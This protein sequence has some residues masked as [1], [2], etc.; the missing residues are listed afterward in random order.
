MDKLYTIVGDWRLPFI[1]ALLSVA[2]MVIAAHTT[3]R[4]YPWVLWSFYLS[5]AGMVIL[6]HI[7]T[8]RFTGIISIIS[9]GIGYRLIVNFFTLPTGSGPQV[10]PIRMNQVVESGSIDFILGFYG[11]APLHFVYVAFTSIILDIDSFDA[12]FIYAVIIGILLPLIVISVCRTIEVHNEQLLL[13][14]AILAVC[15]TEAIRRSYWIVPQST[16]SVFFWI[17]IFI[18]TLHI[19]DNKGGRGLPVLLI[20]ATITIALTH[21]LQLTVLSAILVGLLILLKTD[22]FVWDNPYNISPIQQMST[23]L[24]FVWT[25]MIAQWLYIGNLI[26]TIVAR[27][28]RIIRV[29]GAVRQ[30]DPPTAVTE[31]NP[32]LIFN[33]FITSYPSEFALFAER[34]HGIWLLL[35]AGIGWLVLYLLT[36]SS[37]YRPEVQIVLATTAISAM[38]LPIGVLGIKGLNPTRVLILIEPMLVVLIIIS[39]KQLFEIIDKETIIKISSIIVIFLVATQIFATSAAPDYKDTQ[40]YY[41]D[42]PEAHAEA[43]MC[44]IFD[45]EFYVDSYYSRFISIENERCDLKKSIGRSDNSP[46]FNAD[47]NPEEHKVFVYRHDPEVY[48]GDQGDRWRLAWNPEQELDSEYNIVYDN[49]PVTAFSAP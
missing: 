39:I 36:N 44:D 46:L 14:A 5:L 22:R 42:V 30:V 45:D 16:G 2:G 12:I 11:D 32:G 8:N 37:S 47:I 25:I 10:H 43:T 26:G 29:P 13:L 24:V 40:R 1:V 19:N 49:G 6:T 17:F 15:V 27:V 21:R 18:L 48:Q 7:G 3:G 28:L 35:F 23:I 31:V 9:I 20:I 34:V 33:Y 4:I 38:F 41:A